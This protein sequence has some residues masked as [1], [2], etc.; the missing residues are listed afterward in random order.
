[1]FGMKKG[2]LFKKESNEI[3]IVAG[4]GN[5]G[6]E[7]ERTRHNCGFKTI[8]E[9][10][11]RHG[12]E[13]TKNK[14]NAKYGEVKLDALGGGTARVIV[15]KPETYMNNSGEAVR[16]AANFFKVPT[17]NIIVI[18]DDSDID[19]GTLRLRKAGSGGTHNGMKSIVRELGTED[20]KRIR[21]GIGRK[22]PNADMIKFVLGTFA[23]DEEQKMQEAFERATEAIECIVKKGIDF[24]MNKYNAK[25]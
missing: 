11:K 17:Q 21:V 20:F 16:D 23:P 14:F 1:M 5:P 24:A 8:D 15:M 12:T 25:K 2:S 13:L 7:Y 4:L 22:M 9:F 6:S 3:F 18:C 10:C 19:T